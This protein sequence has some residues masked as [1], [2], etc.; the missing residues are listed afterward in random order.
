MDHYLPAG[1]PNSL[2]V[3]LI[4]NRLSADATRLFSQA[5]DELEAWAFANNRLMK[6]TIQGSQNLQRHWQV[7]NRVN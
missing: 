7:C 1:A 3:K 5:R 6:T 2:D 4:S